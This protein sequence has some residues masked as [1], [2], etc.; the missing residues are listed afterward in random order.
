M[1]IYVGIHEFAW[2]DMDIERSLMVKSA[3][4]PCS[5]YFLTRLKSVGRLMLKIENGDSMTAQ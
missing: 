2:E 3:A 4:G 1:M 5:R